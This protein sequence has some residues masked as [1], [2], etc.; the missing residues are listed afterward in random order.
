MPVK[1]SKSIIGRN[2]NDPTSSNLRAG[3]HDHG[4]RPATE[5][6]PDMASTT[7]APVLGDGT[8]VEWWFA[9]KPTTVAGQWGVNIGSQ[10]R[11]DLWE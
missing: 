11:G 6:S 7:L 4:K 3:K 8:A 1:H 2:F 10:E 5:P 9:F